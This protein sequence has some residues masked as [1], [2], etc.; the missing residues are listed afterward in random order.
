MI[1]KYSPTMSQKETDSLIGQVYMY[2]KDRMPGNKNCHISFV[3][4]EHEKTYEQLKGI[5]K[6]C[7]LAKPY[8][9]EWKGCS[10]D[11][12]DVKKFMKYEL[13]FVRDP[14]LEEIAWM[15]KSYEASLLPGDQ[16]IT[17]EFRKKLIQECKQFKQPK[18]FS[19]A[20]KSEMMDLITSFEAF[21]ASCDTASR[22][23]KWEEVF[24][25]N[26]EREQALKL[27]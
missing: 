26:E 21:A 8:L 10:F 4:P 13:D 20:S 18:S 1:F 17:S 7:A 3:E 12:K 6:L 23:E 2:M 14:S 27:Y 9:E 22:K 15:I 19:T 25:T 24:L 11:L 16:A 5:H